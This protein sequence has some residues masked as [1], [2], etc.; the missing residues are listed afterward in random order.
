MHPILYCRPPRHVCSLPVPN[1]SNTCSTCFYP[2][3]LSMSSLVVCVSVLY[4]T[5]LNPICG[6]FLFLA[7]HKCMG[8]PWRSE[9]YTLAS[10]FWIFDK[11]YKS[12]IISHLRGLCI[13]NC[14]IGLAPVSRALDLWDLKLAKW[15]LIV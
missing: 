7:Q 3:N 6:F 8:E 14:R 4:S 1:P 12:N 10:Q 15:V 2:E 13:P 9:F 11:F 5:F